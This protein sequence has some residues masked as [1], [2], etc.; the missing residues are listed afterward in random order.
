MPP[1]HHPD[2]SIRTTS[3]GMVLHILG[4]TIPT[5]FHD[6]TNNLHHSRSDLKSSV[7]RTQQWSFFGFMDKSTIRHKNALPGGTALHA[8]ARR[9]IRESSCLFVQALRLV[10]RSKLISFIS[11]RRISINSVSSFIPRNSITVVGPSRFSSDSG[12]PSSAQVSI[13]VTKSQAH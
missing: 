6:D 3:A 7:S 2:A 12:S 8:C 4:V 5:P 10:H 11:G 9:L 13:V 1:H